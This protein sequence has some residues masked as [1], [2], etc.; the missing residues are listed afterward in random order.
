MIR[1]LLFALLV[2][3]PAAAAELRPFVP[4]SAAAIAAAHQ[5]RAHVVA[6]W[7]IDCLPCLAELPL[8]RKLADG[9]LAVVLVATDDLAAHAAR[10]SRLLDRHGLTVP[11]YAFADPFVER[12]RFEVA[13]GWQGELPRTHLVAADGAVQ[14]VTGLVAEETIAS[15][16]RQQ[17]V[18]HDPGART[19]AAR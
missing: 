16:L 19:A 6:Y 13:R 7:S 4:G 2:A 8:W 18:G 9:G 15:W 5:G 11:A 12:L 14:P 17:G 1:L 3:A 10:L